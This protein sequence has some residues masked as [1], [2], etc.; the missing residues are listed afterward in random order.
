DWALFP[1]AR[2]PGWPGDLCGRHG[3][4]DLR[5]L[6]TQHQ[7][8][9]SAHGVD[10]RD[11][12]SGRQVPAWGTGADWTMAWHCRGDVWRGAFAIFGQR[13]SGMSALSALW[14]SIILG[15]CAQIF[16][17]RGVARG[18]TP[19]TGSYLLLLRSVWVWAWAVCFVFATGL[20]MIAISSMQVS[21]A[22]P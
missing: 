17:R 6:A 5:C 20:W 4:L 3:A 2:G 1:S 10:L 8:S 11:R 19:G 21:Y 7:L 22:F 16:L 18:F 13:G 9:L 15:S 14:A 12:R